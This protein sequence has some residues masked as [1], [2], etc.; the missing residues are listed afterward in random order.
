[1]SAALVLM[2]VILLAVVVGAALVR[3]A[4]REPFAGGCSDE[5]E[6]P[7]ARMERASGS[8]PRDKYI[9]I[10]SSLTSMDVGGIP[11][12]EGNAL[13]G[14]H[15]FERSTYPDGA[16]LGFSGSTSPAPAMTSTHGPISTTGPV[17]TMTGGSTTLAPVPTATG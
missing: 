3:A 10:R 17:P 5:P 7:R 14:A 13:Y 8:V 6:G 15:L 4:F 11:P 12:M 2:T 9:G 16:L 1:M